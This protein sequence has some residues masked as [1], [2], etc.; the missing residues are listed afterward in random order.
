MRL[1]ETTSPRILAQHDR[2]GLAPPL[3]PERVVYDRILLDLPRRKGARGVALFVS[4][5]LLAGVLL[6]CGTLGGRTRGAPLYE[7]DGSTSDFAYFGV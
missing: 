1:G 4:A 5:M 2:R 3:Q 6:G 7:V